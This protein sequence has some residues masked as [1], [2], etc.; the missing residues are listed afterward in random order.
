[1]LLFIDD[2]IVSDTVKIYDTLK[3]LKDGITI[4]QPEIRDT[5]WGW[6]QLWQL[7]GVLLSGILSYWIAF[8]AFKKNI[9]REDSKETK[10]LSEIRNIFYL[11]LTDFKRG[12]GTQINTINSISAQFKSDIPKLRS[13]WPHFRIQIELLPNQFENI[14]LTDIFKVLVSNKTDNIQLRNEMFVEFQKWLS[15]IT[16]LYNEF[17]ETSNFWIK[18]YEKNQ[19]SVRPLYRLVCQT[20][21][22]IPNKNQHDDYYLEL[23]EALKIIEYNSEFM[24]NVMNLTIIPIETAM[25]KYKNNFD[26]DGVEE[27]DYFDYFDHVKLHSIILEIASYRNNILEKKKQAIEFFELRISHLYGTLDTINKILKYEFDEKN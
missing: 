8:T 10:R 24:D 22:D 26:G 1:M 20:I 11:Y 21:K 2:N 5:F 3:V 7:L 23:W 15:V 13:F 18:D 14:Q 19:E 27:Y 12:I 25:F 4:N 6:S 17:I 16:H 9:E